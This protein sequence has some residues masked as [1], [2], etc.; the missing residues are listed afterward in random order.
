MCLHA[1]GFSVK[2]IYQRLQQENVDMSIRAIY[3]LVKKFEVRGSINDL[4]RRKRP[5]ILTD[6]MKRFIEE[7]Y[8]KNDE[9]ASTAVKALLLRKWPEVQV[10]I[11]TIKRVRR[12]M[13]WVCTTP[14]YCQLLHEVCLLL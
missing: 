10:S 13:D 2:N 12:K 4:P 6:E 3:S 5:Q 8:R 11:S 9:L 1:A 7:E 14:H